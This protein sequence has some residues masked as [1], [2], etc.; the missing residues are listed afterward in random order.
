VYAA[1]LRLDA[2][3]A[4]VPTIGA[5]LRAAGDPPPGTGARILRAALGGGAFPRELL[6]GALRA[7]YGSRDRVALRTRCAL[8]K[9]ILVRLPRH[10]GAMEVPVSLDENKVDVPYLLGRLFAVLEQ[11]QWSSHG[12]TVNATLRD[13]YFRGAACTPAMVLPRLLELSVHHAAKIARRGRGT[14][15]EMVKTG[16]LNAL[17]AERFPRTMSLEDQGLFAIGYYHQRQRLFQRADLAKAEA[18]AAVSEPAGGKVTPLVDG[19]PE[20]ADRASAPASS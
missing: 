9:A 1:D 14:F 6:A 12:T 19:A 5:L 13:R 18:P 16:I 11:M 8:I 3:A 20:P 2:E 17:P 10:G 15:L 4:D 7:L